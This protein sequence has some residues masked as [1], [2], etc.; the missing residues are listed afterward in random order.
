MATLAQPENAVRSTASEV[1]RKP[2]SGRLVSLDA[3]R[4]AIMLLLISHGFGFSVLSSYPNWAWLANHLA[5]FVYPEPPTQGR[6]GRESDEGEGDECSSHRLHMGMP[7]SCRTTPTTVRMAS[8]ICVCRLRRRNEW[9]SSK[10]AAAM[11]I[12]AGKEKKLMAP[13]GDRNGGR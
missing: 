1:E 3:Y 9:R 13:S 12:I 2:S 5:S 10:M 6:L 4:G 7:P 11:G 8:T